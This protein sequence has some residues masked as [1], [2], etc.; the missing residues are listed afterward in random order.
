MWLAKSD[1]QLACAV[2][3]SAT[4]ELA[5]CGRLLSM[6]SERGASLSEYAILIALVVVASLGAISLLQSRSEAEFERT[7]E[8]IGTPRE[9]APDI[10][11][12]LPDP[13]DW[14]AQPPAPTTTTAPPPL[15]S[16]K[17]L[18][19]GAAQSDAAPGICFSP[20][21]PGQ[22]GSP[23][24]EVVCDGSNGQLVSLVGD[25]TVA[26]VQFGDPANAGMCLTQ[27][28]TGMELHPC[29]SSASQLFDLT[30]TAT[31]S[32]VLTNQSSGQCLQAG[33]GVMSVGVCDQN[34]GQSFVL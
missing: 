29:N 12:D 27:A 23:I 32:L 24:S 3:I 31:G 9:F 14:I 25:A 19:S 33:T 11:T 34:L 18:A 15:H 1:L 10:S 17:I 26:T 8:D 7:A 2:W 30:S 5:C 13:P 6:A 22:A 28:A 20:T 16:G 4:K 21:G